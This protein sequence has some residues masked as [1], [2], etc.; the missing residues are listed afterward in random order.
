VQ[1]TT[2]A[3]ATSGRNA[4]KSG[5]AMAIVAIPVVLPQLPVLRMFEVSTSICNTSLQSLLKFLHSLVS[6]FLRQAVSDW[7]QHFCQFDDCLRVYYHNLR[8]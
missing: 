5:M 6:W 3:K 1:N 4:P 7:L 2:V 8:H